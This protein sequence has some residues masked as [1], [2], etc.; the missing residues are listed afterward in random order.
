MG[1][2]NTNRDLGWVEVPAGWTTPGGRVRRR[3][4]VSPDE[5]VIRSRGRRVLP[6]TFSPERPAWQAV[7]RK[8]DFQQEAD[9]GPCPVQVQL[10]TQEVQFTTGEE[11]DQE[12]FKTRKSDSA[13]LTR[14]AALSK[15]QL[16]SLLGSLTS[17]QPELQARLEALLPQPDLTPAL[18][19]LHNLRKNIYIAMPASRLA[20]MSDS[21]AFN[22]VKDH[23]QA[24]RRCVQDTVTMLVECEQWKGVVQWAELAWPLVTSTPRWP[25]PAHN[26]SRLHCLR[27]LARAVLRAAEHG[28]LLPPARAALARLVESSPE[29]ETHSDLQL[30]KERLQQ[31]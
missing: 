11:L 4:P 6:T 23:L 3:L 17:D 2:T 19:N 16:V 30:F 22:W 21:G 7:R 18:T 25:C 28:A 1:D 29:V 9:V 27:L 12:K 20:A 13:V 15:Q 5:L 8:I 31:S 14:A 10:E 26:A 24:F